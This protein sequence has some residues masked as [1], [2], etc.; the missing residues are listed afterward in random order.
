M[1]VLVYWGWG[2]SWVSLFIYLAI[3][4]LV[5]MC[6]IDFKHMILPDQ[7][8]L[9]LAGLGIG[10]VLLS[11]P[12]S[13]S[14]GVALFGMAVGAFLYAMVIYLLGRLV[15]CMKRQQA[16]GLGDVKFMAVAGVWMG[17]SSLP[18]LLMCGG[19][20]GVGLALFWKKM[21]GE[22]RF[23]FGPALIIAFFIV[24]LLQSPAL[25]GAFGT[26]P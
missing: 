16:L 14:Y 11:L 19:I 24:L 22:D 21:S 1:A 6:A 3:P 15:G 2:F 8:N 17:L 5:A 20:L 12:S 4:F 26:S 13:V 18:L 25:D 10:Y 9:I 7:I 23:P